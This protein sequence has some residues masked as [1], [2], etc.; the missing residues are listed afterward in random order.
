MSLSGWI[1]MLGAWLFVG[2][3]FVYCFARILFGNQ[4]Q[5]TE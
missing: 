5:M 1:F 2:T 4:N 3:L